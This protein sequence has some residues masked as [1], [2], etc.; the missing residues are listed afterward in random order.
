MPSKLFS[1]WR[2]H[3]EREN[4]FDPLFIKY[5]NYQL[6][7]EYLAN[8]AQKM[9]PPATFDMRQMLAQLPASRQAQNDNVKAQMEQSWADANKLVELA[10]WFVNLN[11]LQT[12]CCFQLGQSVLERCWPT[13]TQSTCAGMGP[14]ANF[15]SAI[16][17][18]GGSMASCKVRQGGKHWACICILYS[19]VS[20]QNQCGPRSSWNIT[21]K[22]RHTA[23]VKCQQQQ[24][25][26]VKRLN[27][28]GT[29]NRNSWKP[30]R[31]PKREAMKKMHFSTM[32]AHGKRPIPRRL[33]NGIN[34]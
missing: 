9:A 18:D 22:R 19:F 25:W 23:K 3:M 2:A 4:W 26:T 7:Q 5:S 11:V 17:W 21:T 1:A 24:Q 28:P 34:L 29:G 8:V 32:K 12:S 20:E 30:W 15:R 6:A 33:R 10:I 31:K 14:R 16:E 27:W 13:W